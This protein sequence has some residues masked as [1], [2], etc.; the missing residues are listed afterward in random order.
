[1]LQYF[2]RAEHNILAESIRKNKETNLSA[3]ENLFFFFSFFGGWGGG[4]GGWG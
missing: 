1:M 3:K 4:G 2:Q